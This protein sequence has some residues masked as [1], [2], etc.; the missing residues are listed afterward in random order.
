MLIPA[1]VSLRQLTADCAESVRRTFVGHVPLYL[2]TFS[3]GLV[4]AALVLMY[5]LPFPLGSAVFFLL[6]IGEATLIVAAFVA[7]K[8]LWRLNRAGR[9]DNPLSSMVSHLLSSAVAGDRFGNMVHG[10]ITFTPLMMMFA[11][12]KADI[13]HIRPF[14]WDETFMHLGTGFGTPYWKIFQPI[15]GHPPITA[16]LSIAYALWFPVMFGCLFWQLSRAQNDQTRSQYLLSYAFAWFFGGFVLA[17]VFS[18]AGPC[19][20]DHVVPGAPNPYAPLLAYLRETS[21]HWPVWTVAAQ[22]DLWKAY[23]TGVGDIQGI[24]AM[25]SMHVTI[26]TLMALLARRT[27]RPLGMAFIAFAVVIVLSSIMLGWHYA[28]DCVAGVALGFVFWTMGGAVAKAWN[29]DRLRL[30]GPQAISPTLS[31]SGTA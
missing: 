16:F 23:L 4:T 31:E 2:C 21:K 19:F 29:K 11:A 30:I 15:L 7:L 22:D 14:S 3:F 24:S 1:G 27:N 20:Y 17:T 28:V 6:T 8:E 18:S 12:L 5:G 9:P 13:Q 25:P 10:L 26:A